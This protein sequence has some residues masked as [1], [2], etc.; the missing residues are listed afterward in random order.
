MVVMRHSQANHQRAPAMTTS[1]VA[2]FKSVVAGLS[3]RRFCL[4]LAA[5]ISVTYATA[6]AQR[7]LYN[8]DLVPYVAVALI[9][10]GE[11]SDGVRE[12]TYAIV[13]QSVPPEA[14]EFLSGGSEYKKPPYNLGPDYRYTVAHDSKIF[15]DQLPFYTVKPVYPALIA[16]LY[17]AGVNPVTASIAISA[18]AYAAI[19]LL[20]YIWISR[21]LNA[22]I[23]LLITA[24]ISLNPF[25]TMLAPLST[26]DSLSVF[27][28]LL[29][30]FFL[31]ETGFLMAGAIIFVLAILI[32]PE[33]I[34]YA[35]IFLL[36]LAAA[37]KMALINVS[38][39]LG[40]A[41]AVYLVDTRLTHNYG[42]TILFY[43]NFFD[44]T[45]LQNTEKASLTWA[46]Y[47]YIYAKEIAK[48][49]LARNSGFPIFALVGLGAFLLKIRLRPWSDPYF[50]LV[51]LAVICMI[52][53]TAAF[54]G[55]PERAL[56]F[57]YTL[58]LLAL[59]QACVCLT[60]KTEASNA[61][62]AI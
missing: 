62:V 11:P 26:P 60:K 16:L 45:V 18:A 37:R 12:K 20:L 58:M 40:A 39:M 25:L 8:W 30:T 5:L 2:P 53:R 1:N 24:L 28:L 22:T 42:R 59:I 10:A 55:E 52:A 34:I 35:F 36:Y 6:L 57:P 49:F 47:A 41:V 19:C 29:G 9:D 31:I 50:H 38:L 48:L 3:A 32:R 61:E 4:A 21:W 43:F 44:W 7:P 27:A 51:L 15:A 14:F 56:V 23:S 54:P 46:D 33:N 17:K 13:K